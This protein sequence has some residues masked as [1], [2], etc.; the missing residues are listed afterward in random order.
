MIALRAKVN[1]VA[2]IRLIPGYVNTSIEK[3]KTLGEAKGTSHLTEP[4]ADAVLNIGDNSEPLLC[5][6]Y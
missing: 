3:G 5:S 6:H 4:T 2:A 1:I